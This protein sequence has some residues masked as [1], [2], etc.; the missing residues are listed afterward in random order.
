MDILDQIRL[1]YQRFPDDQSYHLYADDV[2]FKDPL[3]Q[4]RGVDRYRRM[5]GLIDRLFKQINLDLHHIEYASPSQI[6]TRWTLSWVAPVPWQPPM[7][8]PGHSE[9]EIG[10]GGKIISHID[11][12]HCSR[13]AVLGQLFGKK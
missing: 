2:Y 10:D 4:F 11:Y 5:I 7:S 9:L 1:D 12:W 6:V 13:L 3:N 8:I